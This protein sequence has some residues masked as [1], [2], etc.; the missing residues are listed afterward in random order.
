MAFLASLPYR[1]H[2]QVLQDPF[3]RPLLVAHPKGSEGSTWDTWILALFLTSC[4]SPAAIR[5]LLLPLGELV[6]A[7]G[8]HSLKADTG[9]KKLQQ[10]NKTKCLPELVLGAFLCVVLVWNKM[11]TERFFSGTAVPG[12]ENA[13]SGAFALG[14]RLS[15]HLMLANEHFP[16]ACSACCEGVAST[17][18]AI[19]V[20]KIASFDTLK[21][22]W[23]TAKAEIKVLSTRI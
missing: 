17:W 3:S 22:P 2:P 14:L 12:R 11:Q 21:P 19:Q 20:M 5:W 23:G 1:P 15:K 8:R 9:R 16:R 6:R 4:L 10:A 7:Q 18:S 13:L